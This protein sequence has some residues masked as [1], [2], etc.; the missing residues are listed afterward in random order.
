MRETRLSG[1]EGGARFNPL[2]LPLSVVLSR[3][4][5]NAL[6]DTQLQLGGL[7]LPLASNH[8]TMSLR[9]YSWGKAGVNRLITARIKGLLRERL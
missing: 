8:L 3:C 9:S 5:P 7:R 1:S 2:S 6:I 4:A